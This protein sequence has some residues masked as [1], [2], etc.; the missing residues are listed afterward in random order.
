MAAILDSPPS[1]DL[2]T[3]SMPTRTLGR[4]NWD[5]S[6]ITLGG[7]KWDTL[8]TDGEAIDLVHRAIELGVNT[9]DTAFI[10]GNGES[11]RKLGLALE[12]IRD[13]YWVN[14]KVID[15]TY[16]GAMRQMETSLGRLRTDRVDLMFVH[17]LDNEDH[18]RQI[19]A[20]NSVL[21]AI[22]EFLSAGHIRHIGISGHWAKDVM[23]RIIQ[24]FP[25]EAV[26]FPVG[27]FN[28]AYD[29]SFVDTVLPIARE[30]G[31]AVLGMKVMGAGRI[32]KARSIEPYLRYSLN[33][34]IDTAVIG[35]DTIEQLESNV[36]VAKG[37]LD[38]LSEAEELGL[39]PEAI[40]ITQ[41]WDDGEFAW[42][43]GYKLKT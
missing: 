18:Y 15:R 7:V 13:N 33:L 35:V 42:V 8:R 38:P 9:F 24:E 27:L 32:K 14:T 26:L 40:A 25:F 10:Y 31:M 20:P 17:S 41:S 39:Y 30:R 43:D 3:A 28:L 5:A 37:A 34:P 19:M 2:L 29:Y 16:D 4:F 21:K 11:E 6:L 36:M 23:A 12:G 1:R 22:E